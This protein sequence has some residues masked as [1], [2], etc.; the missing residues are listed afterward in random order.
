MT[1]AERCVEDVRSAVAALGELVTPCS[2]HS[3]AYSCFYFN[4]SRANPGGSYEGVLCS[5]AK[6]CSFLLGLL[7][8]TPEPVQPKEFGSKDWEIAE[9]H[10]NTAFQAYQTLFWPDP[11]QEKELSS[12]WQRVREVAAP[13]PR[14][15]ENLFQNGIAMSGNADCNSDSETTPIFS[16]CETK[17]SHESLYSYR[18]DLLS[19]NCFVNSSSASPSWST[20]SWSAETIHCAMS[21]ASDALIPKL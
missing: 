19:E 17:L 18:S 10:L 9:H 21:T 8:A 6:Q 14:W 15:M 2:T 3:V 13:E 11:D 12:Q 4:L 5:P 7:L 20:V 16:E 1:A